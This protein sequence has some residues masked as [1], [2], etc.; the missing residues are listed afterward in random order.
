MHHVTDKNKFNPSNSK[1]IC[2]N[3]IIY[4]NIVKVFF[5]KI[6]FLMDD[7]YSV[8]EIKIFFSY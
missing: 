2:Y 7:N 6:S 5:L 8:N 4:Y 3:K 1:N